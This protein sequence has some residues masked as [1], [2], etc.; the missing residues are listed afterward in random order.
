MKYTFLDS[1]AFSMSRESRKN[2]PNKSS[3]R[4]FYE[5]RYFW[6][7]I[8]DYAQFILSQKGSIDYYANVDTSHYPDI[9]WN[10]QKYL[11]EE[12]GL[13][14]LPVIH[15]GESLSWIKKYLDAGYEYIC[16]GGVAKTKGRSIDFHTWGNKAFHIICPESNNRLPIIKVHGFAI[17]SIPLMWEYPW[18]SVDSV[19]WKK[20]S[21]Y[22]Q[23]LFPRWTP[24]KGWNFRN[25]PLILFMDKQSKYT[26]RTGKGRHYLGLNA[27]SKRTIRRWLRE[28]E[29]PMGV[30]KKGEVIESGITN[31]DHWRCKATIEYFERLSQSMPEWPWAFNP[32]HDGRLNLLKIARS[33]V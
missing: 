12:Y 21:Y 23:V 2:N 15:H 30:R 8:D 20:M 29:V 1:G 13:S 19:T 25:R 3:D 14:P 4:S 32:K 7:Y 33:H 9:T 28:I 10:V 17:T 16:I 24:G 26:L 22:G 6:D 11:E 27:E 31:D 5:S 18:Y